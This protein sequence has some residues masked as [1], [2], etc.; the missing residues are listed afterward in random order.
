MKLKK[1]SASAKAYMAKIR[2]KRKTKV[3]GTKKATFKPL[4]KKAAKKT[5]SHTDTKSH[6]VRISVMSGAQNPNKYYIAE[7][8]KL[9]NEYLNTLSYIENLSARV[10]TYKTTEGKKFFKAAIKEQKTKLLLLKHQI[11]QIKNKIK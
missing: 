4:L 10:K 8:A 6:N 11:K 9:N 7:L 1:G 2:A 3:S 5:G